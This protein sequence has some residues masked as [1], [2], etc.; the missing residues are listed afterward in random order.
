[1]HDIL[2]QRLETTL[3]MAKADQDAVIVLTGGVPKNHKTEGKLMADWLIAKVLALTAL[4]KKTTQPVP[5]VT[6]Y[7]VVMHWRDT[8]STT[9]PSSVQPATFDAV[10]PCLKSQVGKLAHKALRSIPLPTQISRLKS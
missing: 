9:P 4:S 1:M 7:S 8:I 2:V 3:K 5:W 10:K 6:R